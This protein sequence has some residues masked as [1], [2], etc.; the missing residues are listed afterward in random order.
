MADAR[1]TKPLVSVVMGVLNGARTIERCMDTVLAQTLPGVELVIKDGGSTDGTLDILRRRS[2]EIAYWTSGPDRGL[3]DAWNSVLDHCRGQWICFFG[4]DDE[5]AHPTS[6]ARLVEAVPPDDPP[7][8]ICSLNVFV[9]DEGRFVKTIGRP[10][11][12]QLMRRVPHVAHTGLLH[13]ARLFA[14]YGRFDP[15]FKIGA[16]YEFL[17]RLGPETRAAFVD[18]ITARVGAKGMS[19]RLWRRTYAEHWRLQA[20]HEL[21]G[22]AIATRNY[23]RNVAWYL[24]RRLLGRR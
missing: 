20:R 11:D 1:E 5:L 23:G 13:N 22:P 24:T 14:K 16:D 10:W 7:D 2:G 6:L 12:W 19:H 15:S 18:Q 4:C 21:I 3:Y 9:D 8:L 17:L